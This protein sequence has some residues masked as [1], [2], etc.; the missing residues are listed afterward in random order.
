MTELCTNTNCTLK[1][2]RLYFQTAADFKGSSFID[3]ANFTPRSLTFQS[4][5]PSLSAPARNEPNEAV[6]CIQGMQ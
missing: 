4:P 5:P 6:R 3:E 2:Q 1:L